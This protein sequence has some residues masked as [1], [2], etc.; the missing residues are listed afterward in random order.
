MYKYKNKRKLVY[1]QNVVLLFLLGPVYVPYTRASQTQSHTYK[2][3]ILLSICGVCTHTY[4][5]LYTI[6]RIRRRIPWATRMVYVLS[7]Y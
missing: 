7:N 2:R 3:T 5:I 6:N 4:F 1:V